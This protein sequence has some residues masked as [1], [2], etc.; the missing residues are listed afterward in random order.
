VHVRPAEHYDIPRLLRLIRA[1]TDVERHVDMCALT[2][3]LVDG[4]RFHR[5]PAEFSCVVGDDGASGLVGV[6][7]YTVSRVPATAKPAL[8]VHGVFVLPMAR[9]QGIGTDLMRAVAQQAI[10]VGCSTVRWQLVQPTTEETGFSE[11]LGA[12]DSDRTGI[13]YQLAGR[14]LEFLAA[15]LR[16]DLRASGAR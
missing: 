9:R 11:S 6:A 14:A 8:Y 2:T 1:L 5:T 12:G 7:S 10:H 3:G 16:Q 15:P 4:Q 13:G